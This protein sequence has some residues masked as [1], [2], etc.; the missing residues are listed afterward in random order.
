MLKQILLL[1]GVMFL[2]TGCNMEL[3]KSA[4]NKLFDTKGFD[5]G[6]R[7][8]VYNNKYIDRAKRN[9][10][11]NNYDDEDTDSD[12]PD[13]YVDPYTQN[14]IMYSNM[15]K[16]DQN[17]KSRK[18]RANQPHYDT[19]YPDI[20]HAKDIA[21]SQSHN[22]Q[23]NADLKNE[24]AEI[25]TMLSAAKKDLVKYKC[26][27]QEAPAS[28][29]APKKP[30]HP[31]AKPK[32]EIVHDEVAQEAH[33]DEPAAS[34]HEEVANPAVHQ[35]HV[36]SAA[37]P[38]QTAPMPANVTPQNVPAQAPAPVVAPANTNN[39]P[40]YDEI[41]DELPNAAPHAPSVPVPAPPAS[42]TM[43]NLAPGK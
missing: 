29:Q 30:L 34:V 14:R 11:E 20:G 38:V 22:S 42:H 28:T 23:S 40:H 3:K 43:I 26:P 35:A 19:S 12:E 15:I 31:K 8:P 7:R 1:I 6:K 39:H 32:K 4:N 36:P 5:G 24:L 9:V 33:Y 17:K 27:L 13:E 18:N 10:I 37:A 41:V 16:T 2:I 21:L 25:K